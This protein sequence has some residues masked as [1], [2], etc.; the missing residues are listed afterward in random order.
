MPF[1][2][3][4]LSVITVI[5][6]ATALVSQAV[7]F[8][9]QPA[10]LELTMCH[11]S[12]AGYAWVADSQLGTGTVTGPRASCR[13]SSLWATSL[14]HVTTPAALR[15]LHATSRI[16][17]CTQSQSCPGQATMMPVAAVP[18]GPGLLTKIQFNMLQNNL[19]CYIT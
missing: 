16:G 10:E 19:T 5:S 14:L 4:T 17:A 8:R 6:H 7:S 9:T 2:Q 18:K 3:V 11:P 12:L 15:V 1:P 13:I